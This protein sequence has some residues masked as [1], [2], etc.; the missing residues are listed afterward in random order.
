MT[1]LNV[2]REVLR[3]TVTSA[4]FDVPRGTIEQRRWGL[5]FHPYDLMKIRNNGRV[6]LFTRHM[7]GV[8]EAERDRRRRARCGR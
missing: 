7:L 3:G 2:P 8:R 6:P 5:R 4:S 1:E